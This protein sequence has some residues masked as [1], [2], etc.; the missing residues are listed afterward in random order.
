MKNKI[1]KIYLFLFLLFTYGNV[2]SQEISAGASIYQNYG[3]GVRNNKTDFNSI[4][5]FQVRGVYTD[6]ESNSFLSYAEIYS[7]IYFPDSDSSLISIDSTD[8]IYDSEYRTCAVRTTGFDFGIK[9]GL[10][11][12]FGENDYNIFYTGIGVQIARIR[13]KY[14]LP[15][16]YSI[17]SPQS[18]EDSLNI[19]TRKMIGLTL[20]IG[21]NFDLIKFRISGE[22]GLKDWILFNGNFGL[23]SFKSKQLYL[24]IGVLFPVFHFN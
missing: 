13:F 3:F 15:D 1:L 24:G 5:S 22:I 4:P 16:G 21:A 6:Y 11:F 14:D 17:F 10:K 20:F 7:G 18:D 9:S 19:H 8:A 2:F 12:N 23:D